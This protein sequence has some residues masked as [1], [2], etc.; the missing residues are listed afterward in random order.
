MEKGLSVEISCVDEIT[1]TQTF[2]CDSV[3]SGKI[4]SNFAL[5]ALTQTQGIGSR[6]NAWQSRSG[7]LHLSLC[8][9]QSDLSS[10]LPLASASIYFAFLLKDLLT[11]QG[12]KVW[13]KWPNDLYLGD[14]K[15]GGVISTKIGEFII[16][17]LGLNLKFAPHYA[18][19]LDIEIVLENLV[20][21]YVKV[22]EKKILWKQIFSKY[23]LEF[24]K[25]RKFS[26]Y[27]KGDK[28]TLE[29]A[30]LYEDGSILLK[31]KRVYSLR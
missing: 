8:I 16:V 6:E 9:K 2:L 3:R 10:D 31:G 7:N 19:L 30:S 5:Y 21:E 14:K 18:A 26:V 29:D 15:V 24:E 13:L 25:S 4:S 23:V 11:R 28:I 12:S 1:S 27:Y 17:G 20:S 22:L